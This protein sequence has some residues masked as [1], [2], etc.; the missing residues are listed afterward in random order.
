MKYY[1][2]QNAFFKLPFNFDP[3]RLNADLQ[4]C[5]K[6][7]FLQN[8][9]PAN[10]NGKDY[11][12]P[13]RSANGRMD[14]P[15]ARATLDEAFMDTDAL[16]ACHYFKSVLAYF[17]CEKTAVRLMNLPAGKVVNTHT[18]YNCGYE[19]GVFRI[20]VPILTNED[21]IFTLN[22]H[23]IKMKPGEAWYTNV[24]L[25]HGVVNKG[26]TDR[27]N[28]VIDCLR[29]DWSD[30]LFESLGYDFSQERNVEERLDKKTI[31]R[32]IEELES[33]QTPETRAFIKRLK[34]E[35]NLD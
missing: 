1:A 29:N 26:Q 15:A 16:V 30:R 8:Y 23:P 11:I 19:D 7:K 22:D 31:L 9:V 5:L 21:V 4:L 24:N 33:H 14:I 18:D 3:V 32:M 25:P 20:H 28:L 10:Y 12:L 17:Q 35:H 27:I 2:P 13:L 6:F 34:E